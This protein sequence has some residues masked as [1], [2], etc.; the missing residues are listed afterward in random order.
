MQI[1]LRRAFIYWIG[2]LRS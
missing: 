1:K 2:M